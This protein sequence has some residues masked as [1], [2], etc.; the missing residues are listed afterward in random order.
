MAR[1][2]HLIAINQGVSTLAYQRHVESCRDPALL[3]D[4]SL[5]TAAN[6]AED[7]RL[8]S[9]DDDEEDGDTVISSP[10]ES[11]I[12]DN[13]CGSYNIPSD[14]IVDA[15]ALSHQRDKSPLQS[16]REYIRPRLQPWRQPSDQ[17]MWGLRTFSASC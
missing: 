12:D 6:C 9:V 4:E 7:S 10:D 1:T 17:A 3:S 16:F 8:T 11:E 5:Q 14:L 15:A 13:V 2:H